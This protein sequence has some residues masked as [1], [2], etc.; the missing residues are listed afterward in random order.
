MK[1]VNMIKRIICYLAGLLIIATGI[2]FAKMSLLGISPVSSIPRACEVILG[3]EKF[4]FSSLVT[5]GN[6]TIVV[7]CILVILQII[8]LRK[9]FKPQNILGIAV[10][11]I[12]GKMVDFMGIDPNAFGHLLYNFPQPEG[13]LMKLL[14]LL[15]STVI[16]AIGVFLYLRPKFVPMPAEGLAGA[17]SAK[18]GKVFGN[19]KTIVDCSMIAVAFILQFI[20]LGGFNSFTGDT[21]VVREGTIISAVI[22]GQIVK[23][24]SKKFAAKVDGF[25]GV[26]KAEEPKK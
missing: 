6:M 21:V 19:C 23:F 11:I 9:D 26:N 18:T 15:A 10:A 2:N 1:T 3:G 4:S 14:Y 8:V 25:L 13:Y 5:L 20:F 12:F 22:I 7:Y 16:I 17:I 24:I